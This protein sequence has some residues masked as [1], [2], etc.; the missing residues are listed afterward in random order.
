[1]ENY[2]TFVGL[3]LEVDLAFLKSRKQLMISLESERISWVKPENYHLTLR[4][5][6]DTPV[7]QTE[8]IREALGSGLILPGVISQC[9]AGPGVF[10]PRKKPRVIWV[11][12]RETEVFLDLKKQVDTILESCGIPPEEHGFTPHLTL[13]RI[14]SI[15]DRS[16][17]HESMESFKGG[18]RTRVRSKRV[19]F[20]R[21]ILGPEGPRY[22]S[23]GEYPFMV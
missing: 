8:Q 2:R 12:F 11:G 6:G 19:I 15:M 22:T 4:F 9:F 10:G 3:P 1:M 5:L 13:G 14:R 23:L 17:F 7:S 16:A 21:S 18:F 20:Y